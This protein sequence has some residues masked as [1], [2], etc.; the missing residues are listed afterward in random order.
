MRGDSSLARHLCLLINDIVHLARV[1]IP[2]VTATCHHGLSING[3]NLAVLLTDM[4]LE[5]F[6]SESVDISF[7]IEGLGDINQLIR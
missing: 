1:L 3:K 6:R 5:I 7:G 4:S 2:V